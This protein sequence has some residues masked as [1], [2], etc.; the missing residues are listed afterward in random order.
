[1][2][3]TR[4]SLTNFNFALS[5]ACTCA[6]GKALKTTLQFAFYCT[7]VITSWWGLSKLTTG[8]VDHSSGQSSVL[9]YDRGGAPCRIIKSLTV[10]QGYTCTA[11]YILIISHFSLDVKQCDVNAKLQERVS[12]SNQSYS[13]NIYFPCTI[14]VCMNNARNSSNLWACEKEKKWQ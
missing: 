1:M 5:P 13:F 2:K 4:W 3:V 7:K 11:K 12:V 10:T 8:N 14:V 9:S 6:P